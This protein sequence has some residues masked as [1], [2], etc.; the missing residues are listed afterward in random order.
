MPSKGSLSDLGVS[1]LLRENKKMARVSG[2][3][4]RLS[5]ELDQIKTQQKDLGAREMPQ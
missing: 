1:L 3:Q 2:L 5:G 4:K